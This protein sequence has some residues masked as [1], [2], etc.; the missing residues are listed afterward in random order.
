MD[1]TKCVREGQP[2]LRDES[3]VWIFKNG[4]SFL[5]VTIVHYSK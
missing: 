4:F 1:N 5:Y 2:I 3:G